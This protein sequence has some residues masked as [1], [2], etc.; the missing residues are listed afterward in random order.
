MQYDY[1]AIVI[2]SGL[3]GLSAGALYAQNDNRVLL[4]EQNNQ[5][6]GAATTYHRGAMTVE[7]SLHETTNPLTTADPKGEIFEALDLYDDIEFVPIQEFYQVRSHLLGEALTIP[8]GFDA[9]QDTLSGRFPDQADAIRRFLKLIKRIQK[10]L[11]MFMEKHDGKWWLIHSAELPFRLFP[12]LRDIRSSLSQVLQRFFGDNEAIKIAMAGNLFY[13]ADDP[14]KLWWLF[15]AAAQGGFFQGGGNYIKGGSQKLSDALVKRI[16]NEGGKALSGKKV[17]EILLDSDNQATG[18]R[19]QSPDGSDECVYAPILFANAAPH[20]VEHMLPESKRENFMQAYRKQDLSISLFSANLGLKCR[21]SELGVSAYSTMLV[22]DWITQ[23]SD[24]K[25]CAKLPGEIPDGRMPPLGVVDYSQVDSGIIDS[26]LF[27]VAVVSVDSFSNW[28]GLSQEEYRIKK[29]AW[30]EAIIQRLNKEW[31][32]L[33]NAVVE[34]SLATARTM[35]E[36]LHTPQGALY[37]F[38]PNAPDKFGEPPRSP[39]TTIRGLWLASSYAGSGGFSGSMGAG[40][41]AVR[42]ALRVK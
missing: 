34:K 42:A 16:L 39:K 28:D 27:P 1:D 40:A 4:L 36:Y 33:A 38:A 12:I 25:K 14:D 19:Y 31:P 6:G 8:H 17:V 2:G 22:P 21:P 18:V 24:F 32:G 30:L 26:D 7:A 41:D 35:Q 3:G 23:L 37:G 13:Y 11:H 29:D 5:F 10:A 9:L 20:V 15:Y